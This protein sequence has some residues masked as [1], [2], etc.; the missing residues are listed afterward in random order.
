MYRIRM[1]STDPKT[2][3]WQNICSLMGI[4]SPSIDAVTKRTKV[5]RG[6]IQRIKEGTTSVGVD[7]LAQIA[8]AFDVEVW[9][10]LAPNLEVAPA[11]APV[12]TFSSLSAYEAALITVIR[13]G[14]NDEELMQVT[15]AVK[16]AVN[17]KKT[18]VATDDIHEPIGVYFNFERRAKD[19]PREV[20]RRSSWN[21]SSGDSPE[22]RQVTGKKMG[23]SK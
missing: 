20:N 16:S 4:D 23:A 11:Q 17:K 15:Q 19:E 8:D 22:L 14:L 3:L 9:K 10:L 1:A 12:T 21:V 2:Y 7:N 5:G 18:R 13:D 6:T